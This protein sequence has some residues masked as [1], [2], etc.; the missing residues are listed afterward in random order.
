[1]NRIDSKINGRYRLPPF[2]DILLFVWF[3]P[4]QLVQYIKEGMV[5]IVVNILNENRFDRGERSATSIGIVI[6]IVV[7][8][9]VIVLLLLIP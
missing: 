5:E 7:V 8:V 1:M 4:S 9:V 3:L 6:V 2:S